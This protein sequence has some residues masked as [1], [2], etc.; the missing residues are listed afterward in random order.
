MRAHARS[1][2]FIFRAIWSHEID[3][4]QRTLERAWIKTLREHVPLVSGGLLVDKFMLPVTVHKDFMNNTHS[5]AF[6]PRQ[7][8]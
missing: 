2:G 4:R 6:G 7:V 3:Q 8:P 5:N 1:L